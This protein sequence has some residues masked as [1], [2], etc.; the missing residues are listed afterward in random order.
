M[1]YDI[2]LKDPVTGETLEL[3]V[4]H[5]MTG[6]TYQADYDERTG[7]FSPRPISEAWLNIT[8]NYSHYYYEATE[9][10]SRFAHDEISAYYAD[11]TTGP[12]ETEYGIRG[13]YGKTGAESI[14]MLEDML[15]RIEEKY[16]ADGEWIITSRNRTR[17]W[18]K[19]GKEVDFYYA[20]HHSD[21]CTKENY[22]ED[23]SEGPC[24]DYW[25]AT[26]ANAMKPLYQLIAMAKL[27]PDGVWDGD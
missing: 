22:T 5:V 25:E 6:G 3:P 23:I 26:A 1:S 14:P 9:G 18:D 2:R 15:E 21:E 20:L 8:Y 4:K 24:T 10:D 17:Y 7:T 12:V 16:K 11:G 19:D 27:R 13:I